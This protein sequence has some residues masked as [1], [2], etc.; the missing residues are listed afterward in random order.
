[1]PSEFSQNS[2]GQI[3]FQGKFLDLP[4]LS[5]AQ[6]LRNLHIINQGHHHMLI[7]PI[8]EDELLPVCQ[9]LWNHLARREEG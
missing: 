9:E 5:K 4:S 2:L 1:M 3:L 7:Q 6:R 8:G